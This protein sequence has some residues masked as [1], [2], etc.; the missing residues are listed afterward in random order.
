ME[1]GGEGGIF[2]PFHLLLEKNKI[3]HD[4]MVRKGG[5]FDDMLKLNY[6]DVPILLS[7]VEYKTISDWI[8][9]CMEKMELFAYLSNAFL[10]LIFENEELN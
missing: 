7:S 8:L 3:S 4:F 6:P 5:N 1:W 9:F 2:S 10:H